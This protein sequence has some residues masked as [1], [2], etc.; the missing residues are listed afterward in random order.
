MQKTD[1]EACGKRWLAE[2]SDTSFLLSSYGLPGLIVV[3][4]LPSQCLAPRVA[5][6]HHEHIYHT[7]GV[8]NAG[9]KQTWL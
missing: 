5:A 8:S 4:T 2:T 6:G 7:F 9:V 1:C 3:A